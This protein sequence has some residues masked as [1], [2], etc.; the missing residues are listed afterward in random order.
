MFFLRYRIIQHAYKYYKYRPI[1]KPPH[2]MPFQTLLWSEAAPIPNPAKYH[3]PATGFWKEFGIWV[4]T[5]LVKPYNSGH[6]TDMVYWD[7]FH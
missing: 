7:K 2:Y 4:Y 1:D 3:C 5:K 6:S